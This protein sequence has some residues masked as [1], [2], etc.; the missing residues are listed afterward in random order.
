MKLSELQR[1]LKEY[2]D[3]YGDID[4]RLYDVEFDSD[5]DL[6]INNI[7]A[8]SHDD[9]DNLLRVEYITIWC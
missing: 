8:T 7:S 3:K 2:E 4:I 5:H 6:T 9:D 1:I